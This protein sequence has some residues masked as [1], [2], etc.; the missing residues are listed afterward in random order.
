M[1][2]GVQQFHFTA[3]DFLRLGETLGP[4]SLLEWSGHDGPALGIR[5]IIPATFLAARFSAARTMALFS[6][7][8]NPIDYYQEMLGLAKTVAGSASARRSSR[9]SCT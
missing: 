3:M 4:H 1:A 6:A 7:T 9:I 5:N 2:P 8:L